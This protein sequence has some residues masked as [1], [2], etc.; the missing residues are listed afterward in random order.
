[1]FPTHANP[2]FQTVVLHPLSK[3]LMLEESYFYMSLLLHRLQLSVHLLFPMFSADPVL[4]TFFFPL[5]VNQGDVENF[6][7]RRKLINTWL[8]Y[9][10]VNFG[11]LNRI[12]WLGL[13]LFFA[14]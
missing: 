1:M 10:I 4:F 11:P 13:D 12:Q 6:K 8:Q 7:M 14:L 5:K 2:C 9:Y 3:H